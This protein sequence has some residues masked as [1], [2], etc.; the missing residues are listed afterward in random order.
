VLNLRASIPISNGMVSVPDLGTQEVV[1]LA[2]M[3]GRVVATGEQTLAEGPTPEHAGFLLGRGSV[4][5]N[6]SHRNRRTNTQVTSLTLLPS[7]LATTSPLLRTLNNH[8]N[9][10]SPT[11][12]ASSSH[13]TYT[14]DGPSSVEYQCSVLSP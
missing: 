13:T 12:L 8:G 2:L 1:L 7:R 11:V 10:F 9:K 14:V 3:V 6:K 4:T 5:A